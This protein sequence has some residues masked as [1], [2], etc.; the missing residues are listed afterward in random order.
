MHVSCLLH[1]GM[2]HRRV[3]QLQHSPGGAGCPKCT[4]G[5]AIWVL[6]VVPPQLQW[7]CLMPVPLSGDTSGPRCL[8]TVDGSATPV[9]QGFMATCLMPVEDILA[10]YAWYGCKSHGHMV[11]KLACASGLISH[12]VV[13]ADMLAWCAWCMLIRPRRSPGGAGSPR[14]ST[15]VLETTCCRC[16]CF[17]N[18]AAAAMRCASSTSLKLP[19]LGPSIP[20]L[21][22]WSNRGQQ[23]CNQGIAQRAKAPCVHVRCC[24]LVYATR[25][26]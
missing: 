9:H 3:G 21:S 26:G 2:S 7:Q 5:A 17:S 19:M 10:W 13:Q 4:S 23:P 24:S 22:W 16:N 14:C 11:Y 6:P 1:W 18:S 25:F 8:R 12:L 20:P 15:K